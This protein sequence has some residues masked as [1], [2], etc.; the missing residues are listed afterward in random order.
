GRINFFSNR[1]SICFFNSASSA[2][3]ILYGAIETGPAPGTRSIVKSISRLGGKP[4]TSSG[5]TSTYSS[6]TG[7]PMICSSVFSL[8]S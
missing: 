6:T 8:F 1:S 3:A 7:I 2:G 4:G 5:K